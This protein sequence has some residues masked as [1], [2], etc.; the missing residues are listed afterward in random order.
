[1][2]PKHYTAALSLRFSYYVGITLNIKQPSQPLVIVTHYGRHMSCYLPHT[3]FPFS[4]K[5]TPFLEVI[6]LPPLLAGNGFPST[7][8]RDPPQI[9]QVDTERRKSC[10]LSAYSCGLESLEA[11]SADSPTPHPIFGP[12]KVNQKK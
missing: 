5:S 6:I 11:F 3:I 9:S 2:R 4:D 8:S 10:F 7:P 1:M 12:L